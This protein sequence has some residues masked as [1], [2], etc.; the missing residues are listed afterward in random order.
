MTLKKEEQL[1]IAISASFKLIN[2]EINKIRKI[3]NIKSYKKD[4]KSALSK[5]FDF[6]EIEDQSAIE[7]IYSNLE[8]KQIEDK[9]FYKLIN[10]DDRNEYR[11]SSA[12]Y[13]A[14]LYNELTEFAGSDIYYICHSFSNKNFPL[15]DLENSFWDI[16]N[17]F[18]KEQDLPTS[19]ISSL[20]S[21]YSTNKIHY[22]R[23]LYDINNLP[24]YSWFQKQKDDLKNYDWDKSEGKEDLYLYLKEEK[25]KDI[26][27]EC[28]I[29]SE[30]STRKKDLPDFIKK[31]QEERNTP[32]HKL[33]QEHKRRTN[34]L[35]TIIQEYAELKSGKDSQVFN[36][37][38]FMGVEKLINHKY[39]T[40][41]NGNYMS[42][43][44]NDFSEKIKNDDLLII[45]SFFP[46]LAFSGHI[47][48]DKNSQNIL[49][50]SPNKY[51]DRNGVISLEKMSFGHSNINDLILST[52]RKATWD[53][54]HKESFEELLKLKNVFQFLT[55]NEKEEPVLKL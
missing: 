39:K 33:A 28:L 48:E 53:H 15:Y 9:A 18:A 55:Y 12:E 3:K 14:H 45:L 47:V 25:T 2:I 17:E 50:G 42:I 30:D 27:E 34:E 52:A 31:I 8:S 40:S 11:Y 29:K 24:A 19:Y 26:R 44:E 32:E 21:K 1:S 36:S 4:I 13:S 5:I 20:Y 10:Y 49:S 51:K 43:F 38:N 23:S 37:L 46:E 6:Y 22:D 16:T 35:S 7:L 41:F 54:K